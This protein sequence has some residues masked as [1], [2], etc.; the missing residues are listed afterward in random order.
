MSEQ[1]LSTEELRERAELA[2]GLAASL[3]SAEEL[4]G[5]G[6]LPNLDQL[7]EF[8]DLAST[9]RDAVDSVKEGLQGSHELPGLEELKERAELAERI[10]ESLR[11]AAK[12]AE[13]L[14]DQD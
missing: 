4:W 9:V 6:E 5:S 13:S 2:E 11:S 14:P 10:A 3:R 8:A 7:K 1:E 12:S